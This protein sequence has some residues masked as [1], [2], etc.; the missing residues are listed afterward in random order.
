MI[1]APQP[2]PPDCGVA[3]KPFPRIAPSIFAPFIALLLSL[4]G[5]AAIAATTSADEPQFGRHVVPILSKLGCNGGACHGAV[6]GKG[7]FSLSLFGGDPQADYAQVV[8]AFA[9]RRIN[10]IEPAKSLLL[11]KPTQDLA[12][13]GGL[14]LEPGSFEHHLLLRWIAGGMQRDNPEDPQQVARYR[15]KQLRIAPAEQVLEPGKTY[16]LRV[17]ATF[18]DG[19]VE[20]MTRFCSFE[21]RDK[22]V[23]TV[24]ASGLVRGVGVGDTSLVARYRGEP[25][26]ATVLIPRGATPGGE[27]FPKVTPHNFIDEHILAKLQRLNIPPSGLAAD[28]TFLRRASLDIV[29][30]LPTP[31]EIRAFLQAGPAG[32]T[33]K[34]AKKIDELL[35]RPGHTALWTLKF[36]DLLKAT[37]FGVYADGMKNEDDAPRFAAWVRA[38]LQEN[39]PYDQ[40]VERILLATSREGKSVEAWGKDIEKLYELST[41]DWGETAFYSQRK[42]L[43]LYWQRKGAN[44]VSGTLQVAHAF[45]GLRLEC[46]QCHRHPH[47]VWQQDDLLSFANF[48]T[49]IR[50]PGFEGGNEK[51]YPEHA[52]VFQAYEAEGKSLAAEVKKLKEGDLK[53]LTDKMTK[54]KSDK[55]PDYDTLKTEHDALS[56]RIRQLERR[57]KYL[58]DSVAKRVLH[59]D[60]FWQQDDK[61]WAS[62]VSPL[63]S[64]KSMQFRLLGD[65]E[66]ATIDTSEDPR[67]RVMD[68][69]RRPDNPYFAKGIIN[70]VWAHYL[71]RGIVDPPDDLSPLNPPTHPRLF[72]E[73]AKQFIAQKYDLRWLHRAI[74]TSRTYQQSSTPTPANAMDRANY[75]RFYLRRPPAEVLIDAIDQVTGTRENLDMKYHRWPDKVTT[76]ESPFPPRN[77]YV[78]FMLEQFGQPKR[79]AGVQC[80]CERDSNASILQ[81]MSLANH[82]RILQKIADPA[83][84]AAALTKSATTEDAR[85]TEAFL[86][87]LSRSP[88]E[89]EKTACLD[90]LKGT[91]SAEKGLQGIMW[92]LMNTREFL[93]QH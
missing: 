79:N 72:D 57:G 93:L 10:P 18:A 1:P 8:H 54:A 89:V 30:V 31:E 67:Q 76:V 51:K 81:V 19:T 20:D 70:R 2:S 32:D 46:A 25:V 80:D 55:S 43:D 26:A 56:E 16:A 71:G 44:G 59:T 45:L 90:Y 24:D 33:A 42:S 60:I 35:L 40:L 36:C 52:K 11:R 17:E 34:R 12:H 65:A 7:R 74:L 15:V 3:E 6:Q 69:L 66:P 53:A 73:L 92:G 39:T 58:V 41:A 64:Q 23:V 82:P 88:N 5:V 87:V 27:P 37:D 22:S 29:G 14:R 61:A 91:D 9:G 83:G 47:D 28:E 68:W 84:R 38:R 63:G 62:V 48:F 75:A 4:S 77:P 85:I 49:R 78:A 86:T 21:S 13:E 50:K